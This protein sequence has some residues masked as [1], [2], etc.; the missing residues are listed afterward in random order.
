[1]SVIAVF[2]PFGPMPNSTSIDAFL[3]DWDGRP[4][5]EA[6]SSY[7]YTFRDA[8]G[9]VFYIGKGHGNRAHDVEGHRHGRL[10]LRRR[11]LDGTSPV[12]I[13]RNGLSP[14]DAEVLESQLIEV[15]G[16][17]LVNWAG[18][19]GTMLTEDRW[20]KCARAQKDCGRARVRRL[21][22]GSKRPSRFA[23]KLSPTSPDGNRPSTRQRSTNW[24]A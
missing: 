20:R 2:D 7:V 18:N 16:R 11:V 4:R 8:A 13:L 19:L 12:D 6:G 23:A 14:D 24:S 1:M 10:G 17:Q 9:S 21:E 22:T 5:T 15:F 3:A